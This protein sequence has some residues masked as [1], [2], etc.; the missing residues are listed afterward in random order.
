[1][2]RFVAAVVMTVIALT[3]TSSAFAETK[4]RTQRESHSACDPYAGSNW[5]GMAPYGGPLA[6]IPTKGPYGRASHRTE[7]QVPR[8]YGR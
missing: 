5:E 3:S 7:G 4:D 6:V 1:M 2:N 8:L